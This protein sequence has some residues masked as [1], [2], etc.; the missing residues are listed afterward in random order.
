MEEVNG[1]KQVQVALQ[2]VADMHLGDRKAQNLPTIGNARQVWFLF[3]LAILILCIAW[4]NYINLSTA[5]ALKR[6]KNISVRKVLGA[7]RRRLIQQQLAET[8]VLTTLSIL[9]ALG[10]CLFLQP[11]FNYLV[12]FPLQISMLINWESL[13]MILFF[14]GLTTFAAGFY[15]AIVITG[16]DPAKLLKGSFVRTKQG[17][18][19]RKVLVTAQFAISIAF[20]A[21][22]AIMLQQINYLQNKDVGF[23]TEQ[24]MSIVGPADFSA[25]TINNKNSFLNQIEQLPFIKQYSASGGIPGQG[26]NF[27]FSKMHKD[28]D[29]LEAMESRFSMV[30]VDDQYFDIYGMDLLGGKNFTPAMV[31]NGWWDTKKVVINETTAR[32]LGFENPEEA[33][34]QTVYY[35]DN[36]EAVPFEILGVVKDYNHQS[37]HNE[38]MAM[39]FA[40]GR[41]H[42]WFTLLLET[43]ESNGMI[44]KLE[45]LYKQYFPKSPFLYRFVDEYYQQFYEEDRRLSQLIGVATFLAIFISCLGLFGLAAHTVEIRTKEIG[46][47]KVLG[48]SLTSIVRLITRDFIPLIIVAVL[49]ATPLAW[50]SM[51]QWLA[52]FAY[53]INIQ[54][55]VFF[56]AGG[57][58]LLIAI[59]TIS[60]QSI[61]AGLSN[62]VKALK[63]E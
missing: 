39:V 11:M 3:I 5:R 50:W 38:M 22:T 55:W 44:S 61:K 28:R 35:G 4:I 27:S 58:A 16:Y 63:T 62:P 24:R 2:A 45:Q 48:A 20:I 42:V 60:T 30:F 56:I 40:P 31:Q 7:D 9:L 54:W 34:Q 12:D 57:L 6:A 26:F 21:G 47:R 15:I 19:V 46:I 59:V 43:E 41:N 32:E 8:F 49:I 1:P 13:L 10:S 18:G 17:A 51:Q 33:V 36:G 53:R 23:Q 29:R 52:D 25:E 37:L 14:L